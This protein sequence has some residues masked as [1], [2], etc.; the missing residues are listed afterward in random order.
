[1]NVWSATSLRAARIFSAGNRFSLSVF[2]DLE[3]AGGG[4]YGPTGIAF[5]TLVGEQGQVIRIAPWTYSLL[6]LGFELSVPQKVEDTLPFVVDLNN[7]DKEEKEQT[8]KAGDLLY[9]NIRENHRN[10]YF[11]ATDYYI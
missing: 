10:Q 4:E 11:R 5:H 9:S 1:M 3:A 8:R 2:L 7:S 6:E